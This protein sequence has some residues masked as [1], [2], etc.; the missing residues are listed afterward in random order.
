MKNF[1]L[2]VLGIILGALA[3]YFYC[4]NEGDSLSDDVPPKPYGYISPEEVKTLDLAYN[5]RYRIINDSLFKGTKAED[6]RSSWYKLEVIEEYLTYAKY[7]A[8]NN[9]YTLDGLRLY[10]G[11][12]PDTEEKRG[13]TTL[14]FVPT[15]H[16]TTADGSLFSVQGGG[17]KDLTGSGGLNIGTHGMPPG[18]NY[19]Q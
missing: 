14:F 11:A 13:L 6:N 2:F 15:G 19:P 8:N 7:E 17:G 1:G 3:V 16:K 5:E 18:A 9:G 4:C 12:Y 10:L